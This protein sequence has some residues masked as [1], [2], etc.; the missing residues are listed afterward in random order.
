MSAT[1]NGVAIHNIENL[2]MWAIFLDGYAFHAQAPNMRF[3]GD[4]EKRDGIRDSLTHN[5]Y[6]WTLTWDDILLFENEKE[7]SLDLN[8]VTRLIELLKNPQ[9]GNLK[10]T[11][12]GCIANAENFM[13]FGGSLYQGEITIDDSCY[14]TLNDDSTDEEV[15]IALDGAIQYDWHLQQLQFNIDK[16][17]W[18]GF[19]RRYNLLQFF[20]NKPAVTDA[21]PTID[22]DRDEVK[23]YYPGLEDIVDIL[24]DNNIQFGLEGDVDLTDSDGIVLAS[25]GMLIRNSKV[26]ID[27]TDDNSKAIFESAGY[28]I[29]YSDNFDINE[30][31]NK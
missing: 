24:L 1:I 22:I 10:E 20:S 12:F 14:D 23:M 2:P 29:I 26:A 28:T 21:P 11:A 18:V 27:P 19:W 16:E 7:D 3:Y 17:E 25:A 30:I 15:A 31:K 5:L 8:S 13:G 6:S 9:P 4:K